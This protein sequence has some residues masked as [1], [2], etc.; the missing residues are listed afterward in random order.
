MIQHVKD[1]FFSKSAEQSELGLSLLVPSLKTRTGV[2][3]CDYGSLLETYNKGESFILPV[4]G[5]AVKVG[6]QYYS[7]W[8]ESAAYELPKQRKDRSNEGIV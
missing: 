3:L 7:P 8:L 5:S 1:R 2:Y 6:M 4:P